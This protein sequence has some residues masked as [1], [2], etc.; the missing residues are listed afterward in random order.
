MERSRNVGS[1]EKYLQNTVDLRK[2]LLVGQLA[3]RSVR[4]VVFGTCLLGLFYVV[5]NRLL[6]LINLLTVLLHMVENL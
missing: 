6:H 3:I 2:K 4:A 5:L 1:M